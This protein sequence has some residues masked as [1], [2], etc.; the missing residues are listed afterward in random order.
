MRT[1][2]AFVVYDMSRHVWNEV[3]IS[4]AVHP[5][6][7]KVLTF[8]TAPSPTTTPAP[9]ISIHILLK[10]RKAQTFNGL[11]STSLLDMRLPSWRNE[12]DETVRTKQLRESK[13]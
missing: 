8:P 2:K 7:G 10:R 3:S 1:G 5:T 9:Q 11:H 4:T 13:R 6:R 12:H